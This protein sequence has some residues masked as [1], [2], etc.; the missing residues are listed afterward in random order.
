M[1]DAD[2]PGP[3]GPLPSSRSDRPPD[4]RCAFARPVHYDLYQT[5]RFQRIGHR[6]PSMRVDATS[7][8]RAWHTPDGPATLHVED[9]GDMLSARGWGEGARFA[10]G[11]AHHFLGLHDDP[12]SFQTEHPRLRVLQ[13][14]HPG[15]YLSDGADVVGALVRT[16]LQ[17]R[18]TWMEAAAS[19][20]ELVTARG[21]PA[22]GPGGLLLPP[23]PL[24]LAATPRWRMESW[25]LG[26]RRARTLHEIGRRAKRLHEAYGMDRGDRLRRLQAIPGIGPW[27][28][29]SAL[30]MHLGDPDAVPTGDVHLPRTVR[31]ALTGEDRSTTDAE[32]LTLTEPFR[33]HRARVLR[34]I[35]AAHVQPPRRAPKRAV[36][37]W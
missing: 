8:W 6:D 17:Q 28:A 20:R 26:T 30:L 21:T 10:V 12:Q 32:L 18:W 29:E 23:D 19:W 34:L 33:P 4:A 27:T 14:A 22:P 11:Q 2:L 35:Y 36:R 3:A 31:Y 9:D 37:R 16:V 25:G 1:S 15:L 7:V 24:A 13:R 5:L